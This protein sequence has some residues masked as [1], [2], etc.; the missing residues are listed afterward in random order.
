M[1][2]ICTVNENGVSLFV[3]FFRVSY[4]DFLKPFAAK[5]QVWRHGNNML[6]LLQQ[7]NP[8]LPL[9]EIVEPPQKGL[10][11]LTSKL[12][13]KVRGLAVNFKIEEGINTD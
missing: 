4:L 11:G 9:A 12:R 6:S 2:N 13:H 3:C 10:H 8:S 7:P 1:K 5:K